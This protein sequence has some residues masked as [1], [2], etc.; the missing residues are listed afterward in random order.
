MTKVDLELRGSKALHRTFV[1]MEV[2]RQ[3]QLAQVWQDTF[4][5]AEPTVGTIVVNSY[6]LLKDMRNC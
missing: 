6:C 4:V 1:I 2:G 3:T 5:N